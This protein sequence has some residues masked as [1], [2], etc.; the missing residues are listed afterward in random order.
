MPTCFVVQGFGQKTDFT[1][2]RKLNLDAS[3]QVIKEAVQDAGLECIRADEVVT[4]GMIDVPMYDWILKADLVI[5]DLSTYNV[6]AAYELGVRYAV[7]EKATIIVAESEFVNPFDFSHIVMYRYRHLGEDVG[8]TEAIRFRRELAVAIRAAMA[9][10]G[11]DSPLYQLMALT[12]PQRRATAAAA[13]VAAVPAAGEDPSAKQLLDFALAAINRSDFLGARAFLTA[14]RETRPN[15]TSVLQRLVLA[16][17]KS[18]H[19]DE[20]TALEDARKILE[21]PLNASTT[22]DPE[23]LGLWGAVHKRLWTLGLGSPHLSASV[24]AYER[25]FYL[26][27]DYYNGINL[28][29]LLNLRAAERQKAGDI[30]EAIADFVLARRIRREVIPLCDVA[31]QADNVSADD[32][33]WISATRWEAAVGLDDGDGTAEWQRKSEGAASAPWMLETTCGQIA[34]LRALL[35]ESP[36]THVTA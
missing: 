5:A 31:L 18:R 36:L 1:T 20:H 28:A 24:S 15:D 34:R 4:S 21:G 27:Q 3:Y 8:R 35:A 14:L 17:Y 11:A 16:T 29:F 23:T 33:Y 26:R 30:V 19:P 12:P 9:G 7:K 25:G 13:V 2:G 22:N 32:R 10:G 6:N